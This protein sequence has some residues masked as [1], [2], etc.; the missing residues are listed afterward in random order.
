G[1]TNQVTVVD[2]FALADALA[3]A[4]RELTALDDAC[5]RFR[6]DSELACLNRAGGGGLSPLL[7]EALEVAIAAAASTDGL[8]DPTVGCSMR[9]LGYDRDF[10]VVVRL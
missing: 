7:L 6:S 8:V 3:V 4:R 9:A 10:D 2:E 1:V 5:S